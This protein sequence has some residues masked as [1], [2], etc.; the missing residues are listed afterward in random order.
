MESR[1]SASPDALLHNQAPEDEIH[2][3]VYDIKARYKSVLNH[4]F[5]LVGIKK[6][7]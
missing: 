2:G 7:I 6:V 3:K 1:L 4:Q 5:S